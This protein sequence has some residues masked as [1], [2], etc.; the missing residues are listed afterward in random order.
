MNL[1]WTEHISFKFVESFNLKTMEWSQEAD[2]PFAPK[3]FPTNIRYGN[4]FLVLGGY[5]NNVMTDHIFMVAAESNLKFDS[6]AD[7]E[8][9]SFSV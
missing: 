2:F 6:R 7:I 9:C 4:T 8:N 1:G 3:A 5:V